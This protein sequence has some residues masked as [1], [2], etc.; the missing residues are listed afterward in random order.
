[1][2]LSH[3]TTND[4]LADESFRRWVLFPD[5]ET[6]RWWEEQL[7]RYPEKAVE[8]RQARRILLATARVVNQQTVEDGRIE[9][10]WQKIQH[11]VS[12]SVT[13][14]PPVAKKA[15]NSRVGQR[16]KVAASVALLV[17]AGLAFWYTAS[18]GNE[19]IV[20]TADRE[21]QIFTLPDGSRVI[22]NES[23]E[24]RYRTDWSGDT[25][26]VWLEGEAF[27]QVKKLAQ[28]PKSRAGAS[29]SA[30]D[31]KVQ[32][33][34]KV[35]FVVHTAS[36]DVEVYGTRFSV[37]SEPWKSQ[38]VLQSGEVTVN[39]ADDQRIVMLPGDFVEV[40]PGNTVHKQVNP[41]LYAAWKEEKIV[42]E[43]VP[44]A[45]VATWI[46]DRYNQ[47]VIIK[48]SSLDSLR[49]TAT[50]PND[51]LEVLLETLSLIYHLHIEQ[52]NRQTITIE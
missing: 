38:V 22:L 20:V 49:L 41:Q 8:V 36:L 7:A 51:N 1:M 29:E 18:S 14:A 44:V 13:L 15:Q 34:A 40:T 5:P 37:S 11:S 52:P 16:W 6:T 30:A 26:E 27:F 33:P 32:Q 17:A 50:L 24:L 3:Y 9:A 12:G 46:Q 47:K 2:Y 23:S 25:R 10:L 43:Q 39:T 48:T 42:F 31:D 21:R 4:L 35:K 45:E 28:T 19:Q